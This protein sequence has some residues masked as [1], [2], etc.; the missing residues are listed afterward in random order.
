MNV[1]PDVNGVVVKSSSMMD[2]YGRAVNGTNPK[3]FAYHELLLYIEP[4]ALLNFGL[5]PGLAN[6]TGI[7]L[8]IIFAIMVLFSLPCVRRG[9]HFEVI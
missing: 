3:G 2:F 8:I 7:G 1:L 4:G 5:I 9:G 6:P